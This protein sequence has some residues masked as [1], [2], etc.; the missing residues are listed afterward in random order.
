MYE[1]Q[2]K[3]T[4]NKTNILGPKIR[5]SIQ[6][7]PMKPREMVVDYNKKLDFIVGEEMPEFTVK[8]IAEDD[9]TLNS[10]EPS[11]L[12]MKIW[13]ADSPKKNMPPSKVQLIQRIQIEAYWK[14]KIALY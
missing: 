3:A 2:A 5:I 14:L 7:D 6:P 10:T 9:S 13:K 11:F 12:S 4:V 8:I 1:F